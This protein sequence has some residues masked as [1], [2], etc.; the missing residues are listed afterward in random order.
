MHE[1]DIN[2]KRL[3]TILKKKDINRMKEEETIELDIPNDQLLY[4]ALQ[5]H[6]EDLTLNEFINNLIREKLNEDK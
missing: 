4:L 5:A 3:I 2:L 6:K 1:D